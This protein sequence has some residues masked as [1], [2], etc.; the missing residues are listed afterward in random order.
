MVIK[1]FMAPVA[2]L[3][4]YMVHY[5]MLRHCCIDFILQDQSFFF[6]LAWAIFGNIGGSGFP[7][8]ADVVYQYFCGGELTGVEL[9]RK[10]SRSYSEDNDPEGIYTSKIM[11]SLCPGYV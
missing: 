6:L 11:V 4:K 1:A 5:K 2:F 9:P 10:H 7:Y 3:T 8:F